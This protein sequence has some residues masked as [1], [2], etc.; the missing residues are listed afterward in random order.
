MYR[1]KGETV[2]EAFRLALLD[3]IEVAKNE[4][5]GNNMGG[6]MNK[7]DAY[8]NGFEHGSSGNANFN[9]FDPNDERELYD[10]YKRGYADGAPE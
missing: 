10:A 4:V 6:M 5:V 8:C 7:E 2:I 3:N 9:P 1:A